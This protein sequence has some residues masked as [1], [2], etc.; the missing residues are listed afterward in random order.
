V[1]RA[2]AL[3]V[4]VGCASTGPR[5][6]QVTPDLGAAGAIVQLTG[7]DF[8]GSRGDCVNVTGQIQLGNSP[9]FYQAQVVSWDATSAQIV[10]PDMPAGSTELVMDLGDRVSNSLVF[11]VEGG[12]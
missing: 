3:L 10:V 5:L 7:E 2:A 12:T 11:V 8:C 1:I 4:A 9:P 6:D